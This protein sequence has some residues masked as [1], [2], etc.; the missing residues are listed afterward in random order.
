MQ[1][2]SETVLNLYCDLHLSSIFKL[3]V[4]DVHQSTPARRG[5]E[6]ARYLRRC[7]EI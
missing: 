3:P 5:L 4:L 6:N 7:S 1:Y 2:V